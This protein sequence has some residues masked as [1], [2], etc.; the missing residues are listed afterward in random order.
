[1]IEY[2]NLVGREYVAGRVDCYAIIRDFYQQNF[3]IELPNY[4]RPSGFWNADI[5]LY[6]DR[7]YKNGFRVI[8][9]HPSEYQIGDVILISYLSKFPNHAAVLVENGQILHH[10]TNRLSTVDTYKGIWRNNTTAVM[11][12]KD[13]VLEQPQELVDITTLLPP[14]VRRKI[15]DTIQSR[16][17]PSQEV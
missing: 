14:S 6:M 10:F 7:Y 5:N 17:K 11:R 1:M 3:G 16:E 15:D 12:H 4:A 13:V 9:V 2:Q 8:D